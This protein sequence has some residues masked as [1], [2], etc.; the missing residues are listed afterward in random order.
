LP[1]VSALFGFGNKEEKSEKEL[2]REEQF[3]K[4]QEVL[5]RRR[6][7]SWQA[8]VVERRKEVSRYLRD[9]AYKKQVDDEK[10]ARFKAKKEQEEKENPVPKFGIIV[11]LAPFGNPDYDQTERFDLRLPF[12][13]QG[14]PDP[15]L[16]NDPLGLKQFGKAFGFGKKKGGK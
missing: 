10:R 7:N 3:R 16:D 15:E 8:E 13:D 14:D 12:V 4:Q 9:P 6:S 1:R 11:P 2:E 5:A